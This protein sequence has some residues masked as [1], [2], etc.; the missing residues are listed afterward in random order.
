VEEADVDVGN[1]DGEKNRSDETD[2]ASAEKSLH[3]VESPAPALI[4]RARKAY[5]FYRSWLLTRD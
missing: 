4:H 5:P 2:D 1:A 3:E